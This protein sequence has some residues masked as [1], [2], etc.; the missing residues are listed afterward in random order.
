MTVKIDLLPEYVENIKNN[1]VT[2]IKNF[3]TIENK[4]DFNWLVSF[5]EKLDIPVLFKNNE[6]NFFNKIFQIRKLENIF[7]DFKFLQ[8]F[9]QQVFKYVPNNQEGCDSCDIFFSFKSTSGTGHT[10]Q[11]D[12]FIIGLEGLV[13]YK[14]FGEDTNYYEIQKGDLIYIPKGVHHKV[15]SLSPRITLSIGFYGKK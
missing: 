12:V 2:F 7:K 10:D 14:T 13:T 5:F 11:E 1:K 15:I 6:N 4:Y 8:S 9:L 3:S